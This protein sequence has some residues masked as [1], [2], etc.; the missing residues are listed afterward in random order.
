MYGLT[1]RIELR[2]GRPDVV[3]RNVTMIRAVENR[4]LFESNLL[5][6]G[7]AYQA[8]RILEVWMEPELGL[9]DPQGIYWAC[10]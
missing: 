9:R 6:T 7:T 10:T 8:D 2:D 4:L 5:G 1:I 3:L